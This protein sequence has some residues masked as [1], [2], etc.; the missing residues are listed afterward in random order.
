MAGSFLQAR[1]A[2]S[3]ALLRAAERAESVS[4]DDKEVLASFLSG[5]TSYAPKSGEITGILKQMGDEFAADLKA[6]EE[7]EATAIKEFEALIAAKK[8]EIEALTVSI[9]AKL[10]QVGDLG[11]SIVQMKADYEDIAGDLLE[12]K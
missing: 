3:A 9:E 6:A 4:D 8:K 11:I 2:A 10:Q 12:D 5:G 7:A 1:S